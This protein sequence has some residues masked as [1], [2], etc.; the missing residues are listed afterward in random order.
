MK[1]VNVH[2]FVPENA[3]ELESLVEKPVGVKISG[4]N[5]PEPMTF[6]GS[7]DNEYEFL[8]QS[9]NH[10]DGEDIVSGKIFGFRKSCDDVDFDRDGVRISGYHI[11]TYN[12]STTR[13]GPS[14]E[15]K[16]FSH[17][18]PGYEER[19]QLLKFNNQWRE[20]RW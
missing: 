6:N 9:V 17:S 1:E 18:S 10:I 3:Q 2:Y 4:A 14:A 5:P 12:P 20:L 7:L 19:L 11:V 15:I 8:R 16:V 13:S